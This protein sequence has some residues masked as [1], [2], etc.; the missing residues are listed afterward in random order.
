MII[1]N[2]SIISVVKV[3]DSYRLYADKNPL[4]TIQKNYFDFKNKKIAYLLKNEIN[5]FDQQDNTNEL[6]YFNILSFL[7]DKVR[8]DKNFYLEKIF[9][10]IDTDLICYR[11]ESPPELVNFQ[12][13][14]WDPVFQKLYLSYDLKIKKFVGIIPQDQSKDSKKTFKKHLKNLNEV[15]ISCL[16]KL[17]QM[18]GSALLSFSLLKNL[19]SQRY[20]FYC[21][22]LDE[23]WQSIQWGEIDEIKEKFQT[24]YLVIKKLKHLLNITK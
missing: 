24:T 20:I 23:R 19:F 18:M 9:G 11:A 7:I 21:S 22:I 8:D 3:K 2:R 14:Y 10:Y 4:K 16:Y 17:T 13:K 15:E 1:H 12:N 6:F 5:H